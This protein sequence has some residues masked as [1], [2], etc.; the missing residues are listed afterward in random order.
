[1]TPRRHVA[2]V[3]PVPVWHGG[4]EV[5]ALWTIEALKR[6]HQVTLLSY[7]ERPDFARLNR[8]FGTSIAPGEVG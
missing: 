7:G 3:H 1:M 5:V 8:R 2:V 4:A 6:D